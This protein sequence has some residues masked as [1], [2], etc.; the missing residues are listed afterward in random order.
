MAD[1]VN[2]IVQEVYHADDIADVLSKHHKLT[3][4]ECYDEVRQHFYEEC[5]DRTL[6]RISIVFFFK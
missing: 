1:K 4:F 2:E 5:F 3:N 6:V